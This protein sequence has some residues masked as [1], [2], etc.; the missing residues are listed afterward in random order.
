MLE[1][2][3][4]LALIGLVYQLVNIA[5][6]ARGKDLNGVITPL[7]SMGAGV[8]AVLLFAQTD[9]ASGISVGDVTLEDLNIWSQVLV[10]I[11][12]GSG[13]SVVNDAL[14]AVDQTRST[15]KPHLVEDNT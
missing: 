4:M 12:I 11:T 1:F 7:A 6:S 9:F 3:P 10:G 14:G 5:R 13:G 8:I 2:V 15:A